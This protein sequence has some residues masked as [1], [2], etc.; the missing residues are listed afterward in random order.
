MQQNNSNFSHSCSTEEHAE[1]LPLSGQI[2][3]GFNETNYISSENTSMNWILSFGDLLTLILSFFVLFVANL[4]SAPQPERRA[5]EFENNSKNNTLSSRES[6]IASKIKS[7]AYG[8]GIAKN[9]FLTVDEK[10]GIRMLKK[11]NLKIYVLKLSDV[12]KLDALQGSTKKVFERTIKQGKKIKLESCS[13]Q[14]AWVNASRLMVMMSSAVL[15]ISSMQERKR[16][17]EVTLEVFGPE[18]S[19]LRSVLKNKVRFSNEVVGL[20]KIYK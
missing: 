20:I 14:N 7:T 2:E 11:G 6:F 16:H 12:Y 15:N 8:T 4:N 9:M 5:A 10:L 18:C 17:P 1:N 13:L 19:Q 3:T